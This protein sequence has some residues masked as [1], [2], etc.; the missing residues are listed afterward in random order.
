MNIDG[1]IVLCHASPDDDAEWAIYTNRD[2]AEAWAQYQADKGW[3][4]VAV[5]PVGDIV[6]RYPDA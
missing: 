2:H 6:R 5:R 4:Y 3:P 1:Y